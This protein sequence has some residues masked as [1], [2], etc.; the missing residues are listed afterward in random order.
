[1]GVHTSVNFEL[2]VR[3]SRKKQVENH[4]SKPQPHLSLLYHCK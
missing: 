3:S 4:L 1:M 2:H